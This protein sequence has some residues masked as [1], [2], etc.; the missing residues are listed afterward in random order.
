[1][2][3]RSAGRLLGCQCEVLQICSEC[4]PRLKL[5]ELPN[6]ER[7][8]KRTLRLQQLKEAEVPRRNTGAFSSFCLLFRDLFRVVLKEKRVPGGGDMYPVP[9]QDTWLSCPRLAP[10][11]AKAMHS[12]RALQPALLQLLRT[13]PRTQSGDISRDPR[14]TS[15]HRSTSCWEDMHPGHSKLQRLEDRTEASEA[16]YTSSNPVFEFP[17]NRRGNVSSS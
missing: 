16:P 6:P 5:M 15:Q 1:M 10:V 2:T 17:P 13:Q 12:C 4:G 9:F 14:A 8:A 11:L 3:E 7:E